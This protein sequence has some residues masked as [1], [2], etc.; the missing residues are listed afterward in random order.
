MLETLTWKAVSGIILP[1][2]R[3]FAKDRAKTLAEQGGDKALAALYQRFL[4]V[5]A[6]TSANK[7]FFEHFSVE[8]KSSDLKT[9]T[10]AQTKRDLAKFLSNK[11]VQEII[12]APLDAHSAVNS[13][14]LSAI[15]SE[16]RLTTLSPD[17]RWHIVGS[18]HEEEIKASGLAKGDLRPVYAKLTEI[19]ESVRRQHGVIPGFETAAYLRRVDQDFGYLKLYQLHAASAEDTVKLRDIFVPQ[20]VRESLPPSD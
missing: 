12:Q 4:P 20:G 18:R 16:M 9:F 6:L 19:S 13:Q 10:A 2:V 7:I 3:E 15:W 17:F 11:A 14:L 1:H 8:L 5:S